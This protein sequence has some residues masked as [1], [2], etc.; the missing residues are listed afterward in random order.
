M[1]RQGG[2][3]GGLDFAQNYVDVSDLT[4]NREG[5][6]LDAA[7]VLQGVVFAG[8]YPLS[9]RPQFQLA[10]FFRWCVRTLPAKARLQVNRLLSVS[11]PVVRI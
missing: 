6:E 7:A 11:V 3:G 4:V 9:G 10:S 5:E 1:D 8:S 2:A